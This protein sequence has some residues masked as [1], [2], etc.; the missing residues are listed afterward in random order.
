MFLLPSTGGSYGTPFP[1]LVLL[2]REWPL[3]V[4]LMA[5]M[6]IAAN[7]LVRGRIVS[8]IVC[9]LGLGLSGLMFTAMVLDIARA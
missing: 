9:G 6:C 2:E 5:A 7:G 3:L 1:P 4:L 8:R